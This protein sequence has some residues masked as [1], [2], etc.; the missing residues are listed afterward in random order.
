M[1]G[2][3]AVI[4]PILRMADPWLAFAALEKKAS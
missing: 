1:S 2:M 4:T 3:R